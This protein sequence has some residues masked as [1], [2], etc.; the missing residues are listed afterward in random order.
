MGEGGV[1]GMGQGR[2]WGP[3]APAESWK[4]VPGPPG[5]LQ[6]ILGLS[7]EKGVQASRLAAVL[8][9]GEQPS[10]QVRSRLW[11]SGRVHQDPVMVGEKGQ[12]GAL[13]PS[14]G[15]ASGRQVEA[16]QASK[17]G[18]G[19]MGRLGAAGPRDRS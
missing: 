6:C 14:L 3:R 2:R 4:L 13:S 8:A 9:A 11:G 7:R 15:P 10:L 16:G 17:I 5:A 1:L 19:D 12:I 18:H